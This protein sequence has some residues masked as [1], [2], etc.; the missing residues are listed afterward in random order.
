MIH[1]Q[2]LPELIFLIFVFKL[3]YFFEKKKKKIRKKT[4]DGEE[5][6][7]F[8]DIRVFSVFKLKK[9]VA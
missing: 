1:I 8:I 7:V 4:R 3:M 5:K 6:K 2:S 9:L